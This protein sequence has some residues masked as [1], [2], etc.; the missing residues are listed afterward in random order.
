MPSEFLATAATIARELAGSAVWFEGRCSWI[1]A[2]P[3][4]EHRP[5]GSRRTYAA[6][7]PDLYDGTAGVAIFLAEAAAAL[8]DEGLRATALGAIRHATAHAGRL[9]AGG[10]HAGRLGVAYAAARVAARTGAEAPLQDARAVLRGADGL[11]DSRAA[12]RRQ[13]EPGAAL[14][15]TDGVAGAALVLVALAGPLEEPGLVE[16]TTELGDVLLARANRSAAGWSWPGGGVD[17]DLCGYA[18]GAAGIGHALFELARATGEA[19]FREA[20]ER[21]FD[22]ER[23]WFERCGG[24]WPDLRGIARAAGWDVPAPVR[25]WWCHGAPGIAL[26]RLRARH[27]DAEAALALTRAAAADVLARVPDDFSL[28]HGAAG[29][30]DVLLYAGDTR[31]A[32]EIGELGMAGSGFASGLPAGHTPGLFLGLAGIGLF[33]LRL[34]DPRV[35][36]PLIVEPLDTPRAPAI[37]SNLLPGSEVGRA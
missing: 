32:R 34:A 29:V 5:L 28:C 24:A 21:A 9:G 15:V 25:G 19:R 16:R 26:S 18:H 31:L 2:L 4:D 37:E 14:D 23:A 33:Y 20:G 7:G 30:G 1:G 22:Y 3:G 10:L 11:E 27:S 6:L 12:P 8:D 13:R 36:T 35:A 17:H